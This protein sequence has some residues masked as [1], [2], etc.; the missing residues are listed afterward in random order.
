RAP[1]DGPRPVFVTGSAQ[2]YALRH[3][4]SAVSPWLP[5]GAV[6]AFEEALKQARRTRADLDMLQ[7][8]D[9]FTVVPL[10]MLE[11]LGMV[12]CGA[13]GRFYRSGGASPGGDLP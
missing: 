8:Y 1:N 2:R 3:R 4:T 13:A 11:V 6:E 7:V 12:P 5:T 10:M 9:P